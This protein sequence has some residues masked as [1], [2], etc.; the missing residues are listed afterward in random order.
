MGLENW[1]TKAEYLLRAR[2]QDLA[3][4]DDYRKHL[5][6]DVWKINAKS[7]R[8]LEVGCGTGNQPFWL[9]PHFPEGTEYTGIDTAD[10]LLTEAKK[11]F[12]DSHY[13]TAFGD[14]LYLTPTQYEAYGDKSFIHKVIVKKQ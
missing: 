4:N 14:S 5:F 12:T 10:A 9:L 2:K 11:T 6:F 7:C 3:Y 13:K 8:I 1:N